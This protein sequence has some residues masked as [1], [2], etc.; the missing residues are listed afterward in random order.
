METDFTTDFTDVLDVPG[1]VP[2]SKGKTVAGLIF[3][4][5]F[6]FFVGLVLL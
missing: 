4:L 3:M 1:W 5:A 6:I 2:E